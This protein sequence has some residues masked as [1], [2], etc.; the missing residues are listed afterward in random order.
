MLQMGDDAA[1]KEADDSDLELDV[2]SDDDLPLAKKK[3][4]SARYGFP[5]QLWSQ[6]HSLTAGQMPSHTS[7]C[8]VACNLISS[9]CYTAA[10]CTISKWVP[11]DVV[12]RTTWLQFVVIWLAAT[13]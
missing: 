3:Q 7:C 4:K 12:C 5:V 1:A 8:A 9:L 2:E 13:S 10:C 6:A 11:M